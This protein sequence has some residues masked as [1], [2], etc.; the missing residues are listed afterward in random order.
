MDAKLK[1]K[2]VKALR[3]GE[4]KQARKKL[5]DGENYCCLGVLCQIAGLPIDEDGDSV[6]GASKVSAVSQYQPIY[7]AVG[8]TWTARKLAE[9]NDDGTPF[10]GIADYI[11]EHL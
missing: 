3:S 10:H 5:R 8:D 2:W 1:A 9:M 7:D 4:Y 6:V 11:E